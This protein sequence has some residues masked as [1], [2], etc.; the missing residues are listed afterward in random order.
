MVIW[1]CFAPSRLQFQQCFRSCTK[2]CDNL[3]WK[4]ANKRKTK[5]VSDLALRFVIIWLQVVHTYRM[6]L[7][8]SDLALRFVIIWL[9]VLSSLNFVQSG[10]RSCTKICDNLTQGDLVGTCDLDLCFRSCTKICDNLTFWFCKPQ[11]WKRVSDLAL[12]FVIIWQ[13]V[14]YG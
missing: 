14:S 1:Q 10:F 2:I 6:L 5:T 9:Q 4:R 3:T 7:S 13:V 8:V 11:W 12:R